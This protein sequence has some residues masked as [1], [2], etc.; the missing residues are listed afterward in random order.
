MQARLGPSLLYGQPSSTQPQMCGVSVL[1]WPSMQLPL[2]CLQEPVQ[3][4][5]K[6]L[7]KPLALT[8]VPFCATAAYVFA[9]TC[10]ASSK[11]TT[12]TTCAYKGCCF[13]CSTARIFGALRNAEVLAGMLS[14]SGSANASQFTDGH[15]TGALGVCRFSAGGEQGI[16]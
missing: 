4:P 7:L 14:F 3:P 1:V 2:M 12:D 9:R 16:L 13:T 11:T 15:H 6:P 8:K 5:A 10:A